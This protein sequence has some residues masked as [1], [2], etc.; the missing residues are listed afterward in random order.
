M[1]INGDLNLNSCENL[2]SLGNLTEVKGDLHC[3]TNIASLDKLTKVGGTLFVMF[4]KIKTLGNLKTVGCLDFQEN[5]RL[6][7]TRDLEFVGGDCWLKYC[8]N[9]ETLNKLYQV[10]GDLYLYGCELLE[11]L[12]RLKFVKGDL[13]LRDCINIKSLGF[14]KSVGGKIHL[15]NSGIS[16]KYIMDKKPQFKK[17][18]NWEK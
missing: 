7:N 12:G 6:K 14:L 5:L 9:L 16:I 3:V 8:R 1:I 13:D 11:S 18:C 10:D 17:Q 4:S 2:I 15:N